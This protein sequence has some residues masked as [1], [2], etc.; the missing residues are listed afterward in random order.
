MAK[1]NVVQVLEEKLGSIIKLVDKWLNQWDIPLGEILNLFQKI[2]KSDLQ[3]LIDGN[4]EIVK[5]TSATIQ[6]RLAF[7][8][9]NQYHTKNFRA[10]LA[11]S[12]NELRALDRSTL[13]VITTNGKQNC[14]DLKKEIGEKNI[15]KSE[16]EALEILA[17]TMIDKYKDGNLNIVYYL[18][19]TG[20]LCYV[21]CYW[22]GSEWRCDAISAYSVSWDAGRRVF[23]SAT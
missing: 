22:Y 18:D 8:S 20:G 11:K 16:T 7:N 2:K 12:D 23:Y 1:Q 4:Y 14:Y 5:K 15:A 6:K 21:Y 10:V 19:A 17:A 13:Q 9:N 3:C